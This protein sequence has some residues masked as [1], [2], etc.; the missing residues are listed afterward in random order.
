MNEKLKQVA[1]KYGEDGAKLAIE[2]VFEL[3]NVAAEQSENKLDDA[4]VPALN[5]LK[6]L[7]LN[8]AE[9]IYKEEEEV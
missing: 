1:L 7:A 6:P 4:F 8:L 3:I 5:S 9:Q 2:L